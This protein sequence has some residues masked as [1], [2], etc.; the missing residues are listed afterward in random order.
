M[1]QPKQPFINETSQ[2]DRYKVLINDKR[3]NSTM[4]GRT[5]ESEEMGGRYKA[6]HTENVIGS[7]SQ[8]Q[9][10][11]GAAWT[12]ETLPP[13][14][15]LAWSV[16]DMVPCGEP[17]EIQASIDALGNDRSSSSSSPPIV[18]S[19]KS[20]HP[21]SR[22]TSSSAGSFAPVGVGRGGASSDGSPPSLSGAAQS[23][24]FKRR[25]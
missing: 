17:N 8:I 18:E 2:P 4:L 10:P 20:Q 13:E 23:N 6:I 21:A 7:Q 24:Q 11:A 16:E 3:V 12:R 19:G 1:T 22:S 25:V 14:E 9:Y 15:P 5:H